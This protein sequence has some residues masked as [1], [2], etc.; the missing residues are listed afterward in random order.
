MVLVVAAEGAN[1]SQKT[2]KAHIKGYADQGVISKWA[3]PDTVHLV[4]TIDKT[5]VGK[6]DKK[7]IR[8]KYG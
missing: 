7:L 8:T 5:S 3:V 2:I 1:V 4:E 6:I